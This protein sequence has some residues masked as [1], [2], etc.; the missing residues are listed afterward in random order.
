M[1]PLTQ[2]RT[3]PKATFFA[4]LGVLLAGLAP[5]RAAAADLQFSVALFRPDTHD[6]AFFVRFK[7]EIAADGSVTGT[8]TFAGGGQS[9]IGTSVG[10]VN[11]AGLLRLGGPQPEGMVILWMGELFVDLGSGHTEWGSLETYGSGVNVV[12]QAHFT[13]R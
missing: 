10:S 7:G 11:E 6:I 1:R 8:A 12:G 2:P 4:L 5:T 9:F 3:A 13:G